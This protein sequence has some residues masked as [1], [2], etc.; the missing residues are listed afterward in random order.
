RGVNTIVSPHLQKDKT[1]EN[2]TDYLNNLSVTEVVNNYQSLKLGDRTQINGIEHV[3]VGRW[4]SPEEL[5]LIQKNNTMISGA[6][7]QTFISLNGASDFR[8]A[9]QKGSIYVEF[10]VP[11]NSL[12][13]GGKEGWF[14]TISE[15]ASDSQK[16]RLRKQ[17]GDLSP[18]INDIKVLEKK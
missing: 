12:I 15:E 8:G 18:K 11:T 16:F 3:R 4:M 13:Q 10:S 14:K 5:K 17:G 2:A 1:L 9:A 6:G 7:G